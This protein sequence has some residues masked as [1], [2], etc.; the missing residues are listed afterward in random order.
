MWQKLNNRVELR[1]TVTQTA[2]P[3]FPK[4]QQETRGQFFKEILWL[5]SLQLVFFIQLIF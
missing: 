1:D 2:D 3:G 4:N 5:F